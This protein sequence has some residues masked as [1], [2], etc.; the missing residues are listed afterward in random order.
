M[1]PN[2][3][4]AEKFASTFLIPL[5]FRHLITGYFLLD[6]GKWEQALSLLLHPAVVSDCGLKIVHELQKAK[7]FELAILYAQSKGIDAGNE[8]IQIMMSCL[9][10]TSIVGALEYQRKFPELCSS[11]LGGLLNH[12]FIGI[13]AD[14][15]LEK[16]S[17]TVKLLMSFSWLKHEELVLLQ[18]LEDRVS[19]GSAQVY[20]DF[21]ILY[22]VHHK[23]KLEAVLNYLITGSTL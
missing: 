8:V 11:L 16:K 5:H 4:L 21:Y 6:Q 1:L 18:F 19:T 2:P 14:N 10:G 12:V 22:F 3:Q 15:Y 23:R 20:F 17:E 9:I 13:Y 7:K